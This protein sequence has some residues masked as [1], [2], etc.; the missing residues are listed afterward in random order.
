M[1]KTIL[2]W[3]ILL[4]IL[5]FSVVKS[6]EVKELYLNNRIPLISKPYI[7]LPIGAIHP[8]GWVKDQLERMAMGMTGNLDALYPKVMGPRNGWLGGDGDIWERGPYWIDG[9][10]PL[11]YLLN[12][13]KLKDKVQ[14]WVEWTLK[15]Q[16]ADGYFGP[17]VDFSPEPGLQRNNARDWWPKMVVLKFMQQYYEATGD[18]RVIPFMTHYFQYQLKT[19]PL[20]PLNHWTD[21]GR[22]RGGDNLMVVYWLYNITGDKFLLELGKLIAGQTTNWTDIFL[23][24]DQLSELFST[25]GVNLAQ[26]MKEPVIRYQYTKDP[27]SLEAITVGAAT[28]KREHGWPTGL[29]S[30]DEMLHTGNPTQGSELCTAVEM[31]F[32]LENMMV[33]TGNTTYADWLE[34]VTFNALPTQVTDNYDSRQ[35]YQQL[36]QVEISHQERNFMTCYNGT[37]QLFGLFD[38][39]PCCTS[40]LH[41]GWPKFT[42][43]LWLASE[44][45][46]L[47]AMVYSPSSVDAKVADG[48][49]VHVDEDTN[50]P[51]EESVRFNF[52]LSDKKIKSAFFP[53]HLRIPNWCDNAVI[54]VNGVIF[55]QTPCAGSMHKIY[56]NWKTG[57]KVELEMPM[58][59]TVSRWFEG[60]AAIERGPLLYALRIGEKWDRVT[61]D[62]KFGE[63]YGDWYYEVHPT[64]PWNY[65]L[66]EKDLEPDSITKAF[67]VVK[68]QVKGYPWNLEN[69][70]IELKAKGI[71][72]KQWQMYNGSAGP[73][74]YSVQYQL[75]NITVEDITLIPYGCTTLRITEFPVTSN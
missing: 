32:S 23:H 63:R 61:D 58:K 56:R 72:M 55:N 66:Q 46:G 3:L 28:L 15:S 51:F 57:D 45:R 12:D 11:A 70:P 31:M 26:A 13:Q 39:Y 42:Q 36:N 24:Q 75:R 62:H 48:V 27:G 17:S 4:M 44:D 73:L 41:Q 40:N 22:E 49:E 47:A 29:Y 21:W 19:L 69:A 8:K 64:S 67:V 50:Y 30:A 1:K 20:M 38:G 5:N 9:L 43:H 16:Q 53:L 52:S 18:A 54:K 6:Q 34:R 74:P 37:D 35:Y 68:N 10:L 65:C 59:V 60:S 14:P 33:I 2:P 71:R 7:E 25:H